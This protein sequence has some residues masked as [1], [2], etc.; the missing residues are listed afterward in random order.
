MWE[1]IFLLPIPH[2]LLFDQRPWMAWL[3]VW[4]ALRSISA[5]DRSPRERFLRCVTTYMHMIG[6]GMPLLLW[7]WNAAATSVEGF[8]PVG[9]RTPSLWSRDR[10]P[11]WD[12]GI[13]CLPPLFFSDADAPVNTWHFNIFQF[14]QFSRAY[15]LRFQK[16]FYTAVLIAAPYR[17]WLRLPGSRE[18]SL[19]LFAF[20]GCFKIKR[21]RLYFCKYQRI[22]GNTNFTGWLRSLVFAYF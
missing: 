10:A 20:R 13:N 16:S 11:P 19:D 22:N 21:L 7:G 18:V 5:Y 3:S 9:L 17:P 15:S 12:S 2:L 4:C 14:L 8:C 6:G 1:Q